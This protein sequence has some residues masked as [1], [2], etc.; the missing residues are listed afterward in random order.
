MAEIQSEALRQAAVDLLEP[1]DFEG[2][3]YDDITR[4][5][6]EICQAPVALIT[7]ID[8]PHQLFKSRL[9]TELMQRPRELSF[10]V[11]ALDDPERIMIV[12]DAARDARFAANPVVAESPHI[13][14]YAGVPLIFHGQAVG[15]LCVFDVKPRILEPEQIR[16]LGFL[17]R[18]VMATLERHR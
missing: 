12:E 10:C 16:E 2:T 9:G 18:Q 5:A 1:H 7:V 8:G 11:H 3:A 13:R 4:A 6:A 17:A 15:T 14:F